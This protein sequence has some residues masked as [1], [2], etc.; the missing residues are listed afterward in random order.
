MDN[1][2]IVAAF[3]TAAAANDQAAM[4]AILDPDIVVTEAESLPFGGRH[5]GFAAFQALVRR[6]FLLWRD[7]RVDVERLI[8]DGEYVVV[9]ATMHARSKADDAALSMPIA[10]VWRLEKG[11]VKEIRPFYF[12]T[13]KFVDVLEGSSSAAAR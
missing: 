13:R 7:T 8:G 1:K 9:L 5:V 4:A 6:V 2:T 10:E 12:D 11:R 3:F